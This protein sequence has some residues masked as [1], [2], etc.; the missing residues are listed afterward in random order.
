VASKA[1]GFLASTEGLET[2]LMGIALP[3][4]NVLYLGCGLYF[5]VLSKG[6]EIN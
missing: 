1:S 4:G 2:L 6:V 5:V 3:K